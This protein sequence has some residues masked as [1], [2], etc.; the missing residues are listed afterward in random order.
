MSDRV[1]SDLLAEVKSA[2]DA[3][4]RA[5]QER[6]AKLD[7]RASK[8]ELKHVAD[9]MAAEVGKLQNA[10]DRLSVKVGRPSGGAI[11][12]GTQTLR[13]NALGL[14]QAKHFNAVTKTSNTVRF[15]PSED[16]LAE[17]E[18]ACLAQKQLFKAEFSQLPELSKKALSSFNLGASGF[19]LQPEM[20]SRILSC[21]II[22]TDV[23]SLMSS[24]T[25]AAGSVKFLVDE[26]LGDAAWACES[27]C[28]ANSPQS[29]LA[30][31]IGEVE[32]KAE[33]L[34]HIVCASS[35]V[36]EDA[37]VDLEGW[38][39]RKVSNAFRVK[40]SQAVITGSGVGMP[41]GLLNPAAGIPIC[42][43]GAAT[44]AGQI[45]WQDLIM[46]RWQVPMQWQSGGRFLM[47]QNTFS[48]I[49]TMSDALGRPLMIAMPTD[50]S[51]FYINAAPISIV[52][53]MPDVAPGSTPVLFGNLAETYLIVSRK[54]VA[55]LRDPYSAGFC[56]L[57]KFESRIGGGIIC[58]NASRL[59]RI[60]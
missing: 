5:D 14:L 13:E 60:K 22:P 38:V 3:I 9:N 40:V 17:A 28:F 56:T 18:T 35:D 31:G 50:P 41:I 47:N 19:I 54:S 59:L 10:V 6:L 51:I 57:F 32:I 52:S 45:A 46:L 49:L 36:L 21:L 4:A 33:T 44:P 55:M 53:Q 11:D 25:I 7:S 2:R 27:T 34:R 37:A 43:T 39:L 42:E 8:E 48:L 12:A 16:E 29:Q 23:P 20:S 26:A 30:E 15:S 58:A 24:I 1:L